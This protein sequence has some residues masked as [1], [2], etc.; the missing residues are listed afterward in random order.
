MGREG[1]TGPVTPPTSS[2]RA[3]RR[4]GPTRLGRPP[5]GDSAV[6]R[7]KVVAAARA[8]FADLGYAA[9][10]NKVVAEGA[11]VTTG[12]LYHYFG[13]KLDLYL[14]V[15]DDVEALVADRFG[16]AVGAAATFREGLDAL[17]AE[18]R[19]LNLEDPTLA[20]FLGSVRV[21]ARRHAD[22]AAALRQRRRRWDL[23]DRLVDTGVATGEL[24]PADRRAVGALLRTILVGLTDAVSGDPALHGLAI[25]ALRALIDGRLLHA[26]A[27]RAKI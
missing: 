10:T 2:S 13:S 9:T 17:L 5:A 26:P 27:R 25:D 11:G 14:A 23:L 19:A 15:H 6:T 1:H 7:A 24:D 18:A 3:L 4:N 21:D 12:A 20:R 22:L 16:A 8:A